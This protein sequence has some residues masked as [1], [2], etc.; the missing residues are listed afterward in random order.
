[1]VSPARAIS[2]S[3]DAETRETEFGYRGIDHSLRAELLEQAASH[4]ISALVFGD[5]FTHQKN[6]RVAGQLL[7]ERLVQS[8]AHGC[9]W[10]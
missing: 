6:I 10:H 7:P 8:V 3:S 9:H 1:V 4:F 2:G 5:L